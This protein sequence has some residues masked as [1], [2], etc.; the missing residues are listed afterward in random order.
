MILSMVTPLIYMGVMQRDTQLLYQ[1]Y[2][3]SYILAVPVIGSMIAS[4]KCRRFWVYL[5]F[6]VCFFFVV[7]IGAQII[8][9]L[10]PDELASNIYQVCMNVIAVLVAVV[11][12]IMRIYRANKKTAR[13]ISDASFIESIEVD[14]PNTKTSL[15]FVA[16]YLYAL[17]LDCPQVCDL[18]LYS[19]LLYLLFAVVY[20]YIKKTEDYLK[21]NEEACQVRNIPERRI[22]GIGKAFLIVLLGLL[23][24]TVI[25]A[26]LTIN[27][28]SY[29][30]IRKSEPSKRGIIEYEFS[31]QPMMEIPEFDT[32]M[33]PVDDELSPMAVLIV[34][35]FIYGTLIFVVLL[36]AYALFLG[37]RK[38]LRR[39]EQAS[40]DEEDV[41]ESLDY[42]DEGEKIGIRRRA[43]IRTEEE[44]MRRR[45]RKFIR[46]HRKD[47]PAKYE[48]PT[49]I[50]TAAGIADTVEGKELHKQYELARYGNL[51]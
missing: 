27:N 38:M 36:C 7:K 34:D 26:I 9:N 33:V 2:F 40:V 16:F 5:S 50:E 18:A 14:K 3:S 1:V 41:V 15:L 48:T 6:V 47:R 10:F 24:L 51:L 20:E 12:Y 13:E 39:F 4:R 29:N 19:S 17:N 35:I 28:R 37:L 8:G 31:V 42:M 25:P 45:Y 11:A 23:M 43:W 22:Y 32:D 49:E 44:K 46:R 30:D 21:L